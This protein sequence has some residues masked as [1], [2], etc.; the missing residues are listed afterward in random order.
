MIKIFYTLILFL[1]I[2]LN[3]CGGS[4]SKKKTTN[5]N[6]PNIKEAVFLDSIVAGAKY[7]SAN[8]LV[9]IQIKMVFLNM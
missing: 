7:Y 8:E 3:G 9:D 1:L 2:V 5:S 4:S 6:P